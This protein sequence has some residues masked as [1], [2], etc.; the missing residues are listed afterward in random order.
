MDD[1]ARIVSAELRPGETLLWSGSPRRGLMLVPGDLAMIPFSLMWGGFAFFWEAMVVRVNAPLVMRLWG[2]PFVLIGVY[3]IVGRFFFDAWRRGRTRYGVTNSR[4]LIV[5][6]A[7]GK[8]VTSLDRRTLGETTL[9]EN[10]DGSGTIVFGG[11]FPFGRRTSPASFVAIPGARGVDA[12]I[13]ALP[14]DHR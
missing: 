1:A 4:V 8:R 10:S 7:F 6:N 3:L 5:E 12:L 11:A 13:R 9:A 14:P 2:V